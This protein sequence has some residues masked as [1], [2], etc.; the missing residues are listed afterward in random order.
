M[1]NNDPYWA[2]VKLLM[3]MDDTGLS[4]VR[5]HTIS[6][7]GGAARSATQSKFG[8]YS[9]YFDGSGDYLYTTTG[10][11]FNFG[12]GDFTIECWFYADA[13][14]SG[15]RYILGKFATW[16]SAVDFVFEISA[17][18]YLAFRAGDGIP[19]N[20]YTD[21]PVSLGEWH[22]GAVCRSSGTTRIFLDGTLQAVTHT[23]SVAIPNDTTTLNIGSNGYAG[24]YFKGYIDDLRV[25]NG[26]ARY[27]TTFSAPTAAFPH[28]ARHVAGS[29]TE[30]SGHES[31][32]VRTHQL[33]TGALL[34]ET[35]ATGPSY[36]CPCC[37]TST[38]TDYTGP[39]MVTAWPAMGGVW[40]AS[41][42][43]AENDFCFPTDPETTPYVFECTTAGTSDSGEPTWDT[44]PGNTTNDGTAV[45]T[46]VDQMLQPLTNGPL[47]PII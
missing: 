5:G 41:T 9:A 21:S 22:H 44:T 19:I 3:H 1:A 10:S 28:Y 17:T 26:S 39:V 4:D 31:F 46:C 25:T 40:E 15:S 12:T 38:L 7:A 14:S 23:G 6:K 47:I 30:S 35:T 37:P 2:N 33:D 29:I 45:W 11:E 43:Y 32:T 8:G 36:E 13:G 20:I 16:S 42:A 27:T 18:G 34:N 24:N